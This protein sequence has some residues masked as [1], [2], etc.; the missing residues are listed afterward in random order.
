[1]CLTHTLP[2]RILFPRERD[3]LQGVSYTF[4]AHRY[5]II[6]MEPKHLRIRIVQ[7][8]SGVGMKTMPAVLWKYGPTLSELLGHD[9]T[10]ELAIVHT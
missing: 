8:M 6:A 4:R 1:M 7:N 3:L 9:G 10:E 2:S 5:F